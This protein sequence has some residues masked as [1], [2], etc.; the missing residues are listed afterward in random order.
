MI[1][2][3]FYTVPLDYCYLPVSLGGELASA[4]PCSDSLGSAQDHALSQ[5]SSEQGCKGKSC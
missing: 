2:A 1:R 3:W 5:E 4:S